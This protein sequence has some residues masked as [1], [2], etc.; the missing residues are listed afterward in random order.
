MGNARAGDCFDH[1]LMELCQGSAPSTM[2]FV[3]LN[4][5]ASMKQQSCNVVQL[6]QD[7]LC[8]LVFCRKGTVIKKRALGF[9]RACI[10]H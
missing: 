10:Q 6:G 1:L 8:Y 9:D 7:A 3:I 5:N 4:V 2:R